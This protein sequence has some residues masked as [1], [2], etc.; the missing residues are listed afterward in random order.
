MGIVYKAVDAKLERLV[1]IKFLPRHIAANSVERERFKIE[2]KAAAALNHPNIATIH[3]IE[4]D[5]GELFIVME[6]IEGEELRKWV[7]TFGPNVSTLPIDQIINI[8]TQI[9]EG[10]KAAHAKGITHRD[11]K[12]SN[13]MVTESGQVKIMDFGLAK[14]GGDLHLTKSGITLGTAAYM[15][16][17]QVRGEMVDHRTDIWSFGVVLYEML[18]GQLPF[19]G[20]YEA[21]MAY[22]ILNEN[23]PS[24]V[25]FR[26]DVPNELQGIAGKALAKNRDNRYPNAEALLADL[27][28]AKSQPVNASSSV[29]ARSNQKPSAQNAR[30]IKPAAIVVALVLTAAAYWFFGRAPQNPERIPVAVADFINY[31]GEKELT[32]FPAC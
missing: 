3:A 27:R 32:R 11:I 16:P 29:V 22:A 26:S 4:E 18:T 6:F 10:L 7:E 23:P 9:T 28:A 21:A 19:R 24:I 15:S 25:N 17:E 31:T 13:I 2:A 5:D 14:M 20:E 8:A 1:A 30:F 12:S